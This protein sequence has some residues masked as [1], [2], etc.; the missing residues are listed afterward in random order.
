MKKYLFVTVVLCLVFA[1]VSCG[2]AEEEKFEDM[3]GANVEL[4]GDWQSDSITF[5][6]RYNE[7]FTNVKILLSFSEDELV[8]KKGEYVSKAHPYYRNGVTLSIMN[9]ED[10]GGFDMYYPFPLE[11]N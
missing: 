1:L 2:G 8:I 10:I 6:D 9:P 3:T 5:T 11:F 4:Y 7:T